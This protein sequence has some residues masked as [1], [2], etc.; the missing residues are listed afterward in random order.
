M[1]RALRQAKSVEARQSTA[2]RPFK[3]LSHEQ[4][5]VA[6]D[7]AF[8]AALQLASLASGYNVDSL[9]QAC[10]VWAHPKSF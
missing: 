3:K 9:A 8:G 6:A 2:L 1:L 5:Q 7:R 10:W 4:F